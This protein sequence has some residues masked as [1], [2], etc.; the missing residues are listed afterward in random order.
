MNLH[1]VEAV[2]FD[3]GLDASK[4]CASQIS[5]KS[6]QDLSEVCERDL[7]ARIA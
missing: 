6:E 2:F 4:G 7:L 5:M 1:G 3:K